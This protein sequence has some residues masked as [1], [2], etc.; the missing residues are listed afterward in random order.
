[1]KNTRLLF[2]FHPCIFVNDSLYY[3]AV[4]HF[5]YL[6]SI[7]S[8]DISDVINADTELNYSNSFLSN[9]VFS[10]NNILIYF[11][12]QCVNLGIYPVHLSWIHDSIIE[13]LVQPLE[14]YCLINSLE[15]NIELFL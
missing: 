12:V 8:L 9:K 1:M 11:T 6:I 15:T 13:Y 14:H 4:T 10:E 3:F 5:S 7:I 2:D